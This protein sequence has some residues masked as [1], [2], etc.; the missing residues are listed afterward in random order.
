MTTL[1][2]EHGGEASF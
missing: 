1:V 2:A